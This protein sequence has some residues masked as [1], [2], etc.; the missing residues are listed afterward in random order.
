M[1]PNNRKSIG[2]ILHIVYE[3]N[4]ALDLAYE[5]NGWHRTVFLLSRKACCFTMSYSQ[6]THT[7]RHI[8]YRND[9]KGWGLSWWANNAESFIK[10]SVMLLVSFY[11]LP[12]CTRWEIHTQTYRH[13]HRMTQCA[14]TPRVTNNWQKVRK[15]CHTACSLIIYHTKVILLKGVIVIG[16][17]KPSC[18][19]NLA[20]TY[21]LHYNRVVDWLCGPQKYKQI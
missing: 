4:W 8:Y 9:R 3:C 12:C 1:P 21:H 18:M 13:M 17:G 6:C 16:E 14:C 15:R 2:N 5:T 20:S 11:C 10:F 19:K 7:G